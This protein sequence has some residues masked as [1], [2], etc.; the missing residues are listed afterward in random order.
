M[1]AQQASADYRKLQLP[2]AEVSD[3]SLQSR[4]SGAVNSA[5]E[6]RE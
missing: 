5:R 6:L 3:A 4:A 2:W 1:R